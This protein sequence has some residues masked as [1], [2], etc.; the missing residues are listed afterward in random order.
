[1][2]TTQ[3]KCLNILESLLKVEP[4]DNQKR[5]M[6]IDTEYD[7]I[8][9]SNL[10]RDE[11]EKTKNRVYEK[12]KDYFERKWFVEL[13]NK[14]WLEIIYDRYQTEKDQEVKTKLE[15]KLNDFKGRIESNKNPY[16]SLAVDFSKYNFKDN[17]LVDRSEWE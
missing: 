2:T 15:G 16:L 9:K 17:K 10:S 11:R 5:P 8:K 4:L 13:H 6:E 7:L 3:T 14:T 1:M 12:Y